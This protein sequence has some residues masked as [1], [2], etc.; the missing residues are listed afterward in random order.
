MKEVVEYLLKS[1][2]DFPDQLKINEVISENIILLE[3]Y[4]DPRD[5]G[6]IIGKQGKV[7]KAIRMMVKA[8]TIKNKKRTI[9]KI[10]E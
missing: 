3:I 7:I 5:M 6:K 2:I 8:A 10:I 9:V 1:M 4:V